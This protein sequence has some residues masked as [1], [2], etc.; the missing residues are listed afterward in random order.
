MAVSHPA[1]TGWQTRMQNPSDH[2]VPGGEPVPP[3]FT[4]ASQGEFRLNKVFLGPRGIRS[5]WR[6]ATWLLTIAVVGFILSRLAGLLERRILHPGAPGIRLVSGEAIGFAAVLIAT[7]LMARAEG[8]SFADY[9]LPARRAFGGWFW[10][11]VLWGLGSVSALLGLI[12]FWHGFEYGALA[13]HGE[14][15]AGFAVLWAVGFLLVGFFE[16]SLSRAYALFTLADGIGFWP[17]ALML[18]TI[19][20]ATHISNR[21]ETWV[22][23]FAAVLIGLFFC[24][25]LRRTGS[26]WFAIGFHFSWDYAESFIYAVP[27]SGATIPGHLLNSSFHGARW[28]TG[29]TVGPEASAFVFVIIAV[30][31]VVFSRIYREVRFPLPE[32]PSPTPEPAGRSVLGIGGE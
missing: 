24:L 18:S 30:L 28:L 10:K 7:A 26:L 29:G 21:G 14:E 27:D 2:A 15:L 11:G 3:P 6:L 31:S 25:T 17:A 5:G 4:S 9:G 32:R 16:E 13:L 19:F 20:G 22:G 23:A 8:R 1:L 12:H